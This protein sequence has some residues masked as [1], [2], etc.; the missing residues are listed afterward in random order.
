MATFK[1]N[2]EHEILYQELAA[3]L[4][5]QADKGLS[6]IEVLAIAANMVGKLIAMQ[7]KRTVTNAMALKT[8]SE[9]IEAG[10][11]EAIAQ[12]GKLWP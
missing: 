5:R 11:A 10:N 7:D 3:L 1:V 12:H 4:K 2:P 6:A 8:V 9:N